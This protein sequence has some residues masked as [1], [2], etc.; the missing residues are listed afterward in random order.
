MVDKPK[1]ESVPKFS[2]VSKWI[3]LEVQQRLTLEL[4]IDAQGDQIA[5]KPSTTNGYRIFDLASIF[6]VNL[7]NVTDKE[8]ELTVPTI[9]GDARLMYEWQE[10]KGKHNFGSMLNYTEEQRK[11]R[12]WTGRGIEPRFPACKT[13]VFPLDQPPKNE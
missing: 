12:E 8:R 3:D 2:L 6:S 11:I 1:L 13:G 5:S 4:K 7:K 10:V 9:N